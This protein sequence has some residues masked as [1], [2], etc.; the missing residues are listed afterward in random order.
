MY[1]RNDST[2][3]GSSGIQ[4]WGAAR[5]FFLDPHSILSA[6]LPSGIEYGC[7][8]NRPNAFYRNAKFA[9]II[10]LH[11]QDSECFIQQWSLPTKYSMRI[12]TIFN[13]HWI[14]SPR[15]NTFSEGPWWFRPQNSYFS[16]LSKNDPGQSSSDGFHSSDLERSF[17]LKTLK[18]L[19]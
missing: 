14:L 12:R 2:K 13:V 6:L 10:Y 16:M 19:N 5:Q 1:S 15:Y 3:N 4:W 18:V 11:G 17:G 9:A 7:S 8:G